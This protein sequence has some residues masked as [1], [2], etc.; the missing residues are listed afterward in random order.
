M[1]YWG[2]AWAEGEGD[3]PMRYAGGAAGRHLA[4]V[5]HRRPGRRHLRRRVPGRELREPESGQH[6]LG[7]VLQPVRER[8]HRGAALPRVRALVGRLLPDEPRGDRVDHAQPVR[9]QQAVD[10]AAPPRARQGLR[11][12]RHQGADHPVRVD[13]RQHHAAAA[14]VQLG[15]RR[16]RLDRRDQ[17]ARPGDR[18]PAARG[19]RPPRHLR[20][21]Q[22]REEGARADRLGAEVGRV[23]AAG[24]VRHGTSTSTGAPTARSST[25]S[26][27]ASAG[28]RKSHARLNRFERADEKPF[29]AVAKLS[30][31]NQT[32]YE[33]FAQPLVQSL[34][35]EA[36]AE[37]TRE[38]HP[39]RLQRWAISRP[40]S[41][42][43]VAP[44][45]SG[46]RQDPAQADGAGQSGAQGRAVRFR[47]DQRVARLL[48]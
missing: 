18:R 15:R 40:Q 25:T 12:A 20:V 34:S 46:C 24:P 22:G 43:R 4:R 10:R 1:S 45:R 29:E 44:G 47:S 9:R 17:G 11:P 27:S 28:W 38:F 37:V 19:R 16:L 7:Q 36:A 8:R 33:L 14:G 21:G 39:L 31:F 30:E 2:G 32:A 48:P 35:S 6:V 42:A 13:G 3:N 41:L 23:V 26:S 5:V